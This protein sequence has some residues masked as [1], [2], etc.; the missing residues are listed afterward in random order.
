M[1]SSSAKDMD[2]PVISGGT[3][4]AE[5][6][7]GLAGEAVLDVLLSDSTRGG[8]INIIVLSYSVKWPVPS[9]EFR[10]IRFVTISRFGGSPD[11]RTPTECTVDN[12][13]ERGISNLNYEF[14]RLLL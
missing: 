13:T 3:L 2:S 7:S 14:G 4:A 11:G 9:C 6:S 1:D 10:N 8:M 5:D 12:N